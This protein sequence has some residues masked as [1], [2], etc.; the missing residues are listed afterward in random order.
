MC[1]VA[2]HGMLPSMTPRARL[3]LLAL[4][5]FVM[6]GAARASDWPGWRG[7][8]RDGLTDERLPSTLPATPAVAWRLSI[9]HGYSGPAVARNRVVFLDDSSGRETV[10]CVDAASGRELWKTPFAD[11]HADEFEPGPRCTPLIDGDLVFVQ[12]CKGEFQCLRLDDGTRVWRIHFDDFG[13]FWVPDRH[14]NIGAANRRGNTGSPIVDGD[15]VFVQV[16]S[17]RG[18]SVVAFDKRTG[19]VA[20]KSQD[21]LASYSSPVVGDL[22]GR[23]QVVT[24]TV[25]GI[26]GLD[27]RD[28]ALLWR[29]P[30]KTQANRNVLTPVL[31]G[32]TVTFGSFTTGLQR[33]RIEPNGEAF[34]AVETWFNRALRIN[35]PTPTRVDKAIYGVGA[36]KDFVCI[37]AATGALRWSERGFDQVGSVISD[38]RHLLVLMDSGECRLLAVNPD[39]YDERGRFQACGKTYSHPAYSGGVL[40]VRD[41]RELV[42]YRLADAR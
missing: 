42:A 4:V 8:R 2:A 39:R 28:G 3:S 25:D 1:R 19:A 7:P 31:D 32:D 34:R 24:V 12:S 26:L 5:L 36:A 40:Y 35:L 15:R 16:G 33:Q 23:R 6:S 21:D 10:H 22:A 13:A 17:P 9:G 41:P 37:D 30:V 18:A 29:V 38:G 11:V 27:V 20:W 14:A